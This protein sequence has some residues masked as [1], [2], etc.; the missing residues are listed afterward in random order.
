[1]ILI[2]APIS[3]PIWKYWADVRQY[4]RDQYSRDQYSCDQYSEHKPFQISCL[5]YVATFIN[6]HQRMN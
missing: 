3:A 6:W 1:M 2:S 4:S 5:C